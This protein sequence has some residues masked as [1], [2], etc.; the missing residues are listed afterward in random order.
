MSM[1]ESEVIDACQ[2]AARRQWRRLGAIRYSQLI[3]E[4]QPTAG[5]HFVGQWVVVFE[6][7]QGHQ[8]DRF[9]VQDSTGRVVWENGPP[10]WWLQVV[11]ILL[12]LVV[13]PLFFVHYH[14][15]NVWNH[16]RLPRCPYC[17]GRLRT[18]LARQCRWCGKK[19]QT[20]SGT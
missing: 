11:L 16:L 18:R 17:G 8:D 4:P 12:R 1:T 2:C 3:S 14:V 20:G 5:S 9:W 15:C 7:R 6:G 10:P 19:W 13:V